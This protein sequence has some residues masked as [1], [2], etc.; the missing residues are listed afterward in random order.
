MA[1]GSTSAGIEGG[2]FQVLEGVVNYVDQTTPSNAMNTL[3]GSKERVRIPTGK[4]LLLASVR[5]ARGRTCRPQ[6]GSSKTR[7]RV[8][9]RYKR[10]ANW[11]RT[12]AIIRNVLM[13]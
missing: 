13:I 8:Q 10:Y 3:V 7:P 4:A 2:V 9:H 6:G 12:T 1:S 11:T 5:K